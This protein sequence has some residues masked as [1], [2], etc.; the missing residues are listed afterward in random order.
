MKNYFHLISPISF[1]NS[2]VIVVLYFVFIFTYLLHRVP[3]ELYYR[4]HEQNFNKHPIQYLRVVSLHIVSRKSNQA[5][6][7]Q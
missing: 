1:F 3:K 2:F 6:E 4:K 5:R 7:K